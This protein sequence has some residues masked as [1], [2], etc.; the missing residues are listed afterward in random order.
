MSSTGVISRL[1]TQQGTIDTH[2][3]K[4]QGKTCQQ[5]RNT[6]RHHRN[7]HAGVPKTDIVSKLKN[8]ARYHSHSQ[9]KELMIGIVSRLKTHQNATATH[10][11]KSQI[12]AF[13]AG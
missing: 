4:S 9:T 12:Q 6:A 13:S 8:T 10:F 2:I 5:L 7:S 11:L 1:E 3:L